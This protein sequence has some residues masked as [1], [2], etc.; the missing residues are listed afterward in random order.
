MFQ[1]IFEQRCSSCHMCYLYCWVYYIFCGHTRHTPPHRINNYYF[2]FRY[3]K[4]KLPLSD[5]LHTDDEVFD[6]T[7]Q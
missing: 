6:F 2:C 1:Y 5:Q 3:R 7:Y 4:T